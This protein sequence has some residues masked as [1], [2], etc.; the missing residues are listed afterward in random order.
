MKTDIVVD[1]D[2]GDSAKGKVAYH[3]AKTGYTHIG[4]VGGSQNAGHT[5]YHNGKKLVTHIVPV[6]VFHNVKSFI[7]PTCYINVKSL[8][9]EMED[10]EKEG[11]NVSQHLKIATNTHI[12]TDKHIEEEIN[13]SAIGSTKRGVGPC[14]R[15]KYDRKGLRAENVPEL[16]PYLIDMY[17]EFYESKEE[18]IVLCEGAQGFYLDIDWGDYPYVTSSHINSAGTFLNGFYPQSVRNIYGIIKCYSTYVGSKKYQPDG[19]IFNKI[20]DEGKEVGA[21]TGRRR[22]V[23]FLNI[24][25]LIKAFRISGVTEL[26]VNKMDVLQN[27]NCWKII[28]NN[29]VIDLQTEE[30]FKLFL[31]K[32]LPKTT[33]KY[34]YSPEVI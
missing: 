29:E 14:A 2:H 7:G 15:D 31:E 16:K 34:S 11:I 4:R 5:I 22:Q 8:F 10:L 20:A 30:N 33:I 1:L 3:L 25:S 28:S 24:N 27:V 19:D 18:P 17:E 26:I 6:G 12:I 23:N 13:E 32:A 21:T 9:K